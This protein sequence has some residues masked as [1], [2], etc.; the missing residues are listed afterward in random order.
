[1]KSSHKT[2]STHYD[3]ASVVVTSGGSASNIL[4][5]IR[6]FGRRRIPIVYLDSKPSSAVRYSKY[7]TLRLK[8]QNPG[9]SEDQFVDTLSDFGRKTNRK[10]IVIPTGDRDV[11]VLSKNK[12]KLEEFYHIP[13]AAFETVQKLV[14]KKRFYKLLAEMNFP[15]PKT[16]FPES[17]TE[18]RLMGREA[19]F[20]Y[21]I[22][23]ADSLLF[24][25]LF[26]RKNF[27]INSTQELD[28]AVDRLR[29]KNLEVV[30]QEIIPGNETYMFYTYLDR[31]SVPLAICGYDK[32]RQYPPDFGSGSF[33]RSIW[34]S[35]P[36]EQCIRLLQAIGYYGFA[37]PE[38]KKDPRDGQYKIL[39]INA[40]TTLQN[41]LAAACG[42]DIEYIAYLEASGQHVR[43]SFSFHGDIFWADD[44][45][46]LRS[47]LELIR[48]RRIGIAETIRSLKARKVH[49]VAAWDDPNPLAASFMSLGLGSLVKLFRG[50]K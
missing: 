13:V 25:D 19:V 1:M 4:G 18:L 49:S 17:L 2:S 32:I 12:Q 43:K 7:I 41:R 21:I 10:S 6:A 30:I 34:R 40:R 29:G 45:A 42:T 31:K 22:K 50:R 27:V 9:E 26:C 44:F 8:C 24:Q 16:Y 36:I 20:P 39:E 15:H 37:E 38:L 5:V 46:D 33:C 28:W 11:Q 35:Y 3:A 48:R 14:N 47:C 23:P